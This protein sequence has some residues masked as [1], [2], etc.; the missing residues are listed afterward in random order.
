MLTVLTLIS[1]SAKTVTKDELVYETKGKTAVLVECNTDSKNI[2]IPSKVSKY[3]VTAIGASAFAK[4]T[5]LR[6]VTIPDTVTEIGKSAFKGCTSLTEIEIPSSVK[7][8]SANAFNGC[9]KLK[10]AVIPESVTAIGKNAFKNCK[11]LNAFV[12]SGT[13]AESYLKKQSGIKLTYI[14]MTSLTLDKSS[15]EL[16]TGS[17]STVIATAAPSSLYNGNLVYSS[18]NTDVAQVSPSGTVTAKS[19]GTAVITCSSTDGSGKTASCTVKV[20]PAKAGTVSVT[21]NTA[22]GYTLSWSAV[23]GST[24]YNISRYDSAKK[25]WI[26]VA[27]TDKT[28]YKF[29]SRPLGSE[30]KY[31]VTAYAYDGENYIYGDSSDSVSAATVKPSKVTGLKVVSVTDSSVSLSWTALKEVTGYKV[32][33]YDAEKNIYEYK[34]ATESTDAVITGLSVNTSYSFAVRSYARTAKTSLDSTE[35]SAVVTATTL[36]G[37]VSSVTVDSSDIYSDGLILNWEQV[38]GADGY[39]VYVYDKEKGTYGLLGK[40]ETLSYEV[41]D[42]SPGTVYNFRLKSCRGTSEGSWSKDFSFR[43]AYIPLNGAEG[44][45]RVIEAVEETKAVTSSMIVSTAFDIIAENEEDEAILTRFIEESSDVITF[46]NG[47]DI[48]SGR[49]LSETVYPFSEDSSFCARDIDK[50][51]FSFRADGY[52]YS[53]EFNVDK[54]RVSE[55][56]ACPD[57]SGGELTLLSLEQEDAFV[58]TKITDGKLDYMNIEIPVNVRFILDGQKYEMS[59]TL[60]Q[61]YYFIF[62]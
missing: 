38:E 14:Y 19:C 50:Y 60:A 58:S 5:K 44:A 26:K 41:T 18:D 54:D 46:E 23:K 13:K 53:A 4:K 43:T 61:S 24:G 37:K 1:V 11:K 62:M 25:N 48:L 21:E 56:M 55:L 45:G 20:K 22:S 27:A 59:F 28:S 35:Y 2:K 42:L 32:Y 52:G 8:I 6:S 34:F 51:S 10:K 29:S 39:S 9:K 33:I 47:A 12:V 16:V 36:P 49:T 30:E 31:R 57:F 17:S 15:V 40:T 7:K 3:K